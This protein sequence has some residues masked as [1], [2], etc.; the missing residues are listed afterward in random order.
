MKNFLTSLLT[1]PVFP[2]DEN[3]TRSARYGHG[4]AIVFMGAILLYEIIGKIITR[5]LALNILDLILLILFIILFVSL[6]LLANGRVRGANTLV[7]TLLWVGANMVAYLGFGIRDSAFIANFIVILAAGLLLGR[8]GAVILTFATLAMGA[9]L[10]YAETNNLS[11]TAYYFVSPA[12]VLQDITAI[13]LI[14]AIFLFMLISGLDNALKNAQS[15]KSKLEDVNRELYKSQNRLEENRN[16]LLAINEQLKRRT[17][18]INSIAEISKIVTSIQEIRLLLSSIVDIISHRFGY[19]HVGIYLLDEQKQFVVL[20]AS[21]SQGG[22]NM[23]EK[24]HRLRVGE[25]SV[26]GFVAQ[27]GQSHMA[28]ETATDKSFFNDL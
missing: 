24:N 11:P 7:V 8:R 3:K 12:S 14:Y 27:S 25:Q 28:M 16:E 22:I 23:I 9:G 18:R 15:G 6:R 19:Y 5:S 1:P 17:E 26:V 13:Y 10:V 2:E 21:N 4:I 20:R